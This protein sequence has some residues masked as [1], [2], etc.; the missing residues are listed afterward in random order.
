MLRDIDLALRRFWFK[1]TQTVLMILILGLGIGATT[2]VFSVVDQTV[3][4]PAPFAHANRIVDVIDFDRRSRG[5]GNSLVP[6]KILGWQTQ[7]SLF[8]RFE[9]Y[10]PR[11]FDLTGDAEPERVQALIVSTGLFDML[12]VQ[13]RLGRRFIQGEGGPA[14][15]RVV[16]IGEA[17]WQRRL[18]GREDVLGTH[19]VL[20]DEPYTI[21]GVMPRRFRLTGDKEALWLPY[22]LPSN[23]GDS[24]VRGFFGIA[25]LAPGVAEGSE[26]Q[27]AESIA[28]RLQAETPLPRSWDLRSSCCWARLA[29][30]C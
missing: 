17:L 20:N 13:P 18:G 3:L 30:C 1:P 21:V 2:A 27:L 11:T 14:G 28:E 25:R 16:V 22:D 23:A 10:A 8:E 15:E 29:S 5:G 7:H 19:L 4:R 6:A 12:G 24:S 9:A 26:Q